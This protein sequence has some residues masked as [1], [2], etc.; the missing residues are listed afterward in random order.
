MAAA[1]AAA[2]ALNHLVPPVLRSNKHSDQ[3]TS[4]SSSDHISSYWD[5]PLSEPHR[6]SISEIAQ[7]TEYGHAPQ[8]RPDDF[9]LEKTL[10]TGGF[11]LRVECRGEK[12][13][14]LY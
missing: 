11:A 13:S 5:Q 9:K 2:S 3:P 12:E 8:L 1:A 6:I 14:E 7:S 10:G 4:Q